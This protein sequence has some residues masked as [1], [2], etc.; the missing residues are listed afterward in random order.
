MEDEEDEEDKEA[1][2]RY[3]LRYAIGIGGEKIQTSIYRVTNGFATILDEAPV[4]VRLET[5]CVSERAAFE[6][7][8]RLCG[9]NINELPEEQKKKF[10]VRPCGSATTRAGTSRLFFLRKTACRG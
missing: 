8:A 9:H 5:H 10:Y 2:E 1:E 7:V 6:E 3:G 4:R